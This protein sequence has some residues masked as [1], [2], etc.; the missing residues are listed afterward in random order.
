VDSAPPR[1][2][3]AWLAHA[4]AIERYD[5]SSLSEEEKDLLTR[6]ALKIKERN[7]VAAAIIWSESSRNM[8]WMAAQALIVAQ[9]IFEM[10]QPL[11]HPL[12]RHLGIG[13]TPDELRLFSAA[14]EKRYSI[15]YL[16]QRLEL[17]EAGELVPSA[18]REQVVIEDPE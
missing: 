4:F 1:G 14:L 8:N 13:L 9:P 15:E 10:A 18:D 2:F 16:L 5:E 7:L 17:A 6:L 3:R 12:L 11:I